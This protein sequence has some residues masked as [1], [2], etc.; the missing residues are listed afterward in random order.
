MAAVDYQIQ[1]AEQIAEDLPEV[2]RNEWMR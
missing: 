2:S 1:L